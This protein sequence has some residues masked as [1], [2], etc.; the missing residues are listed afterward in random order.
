MARTGDWFQNVKTKE[1]VQLLVSPE[2]TDGTRIEAEM[3]LQPGGAVAAPHVH[4]ALHERFTVLEGELSVVLDGA[5]SVAGPGAVVDV[6]PGRAHDWSNAG[7]TVARVR[8]EVEGPAPM[9]T[10]FAEM[11]EVV[12]GLANTGHTDEHGKPTPLWLAALA[13]EYRDVIRLTSPPA[14]VQR[15]VLTPLAAIARRTGR[16]VRADWLHGAGCPAHAPAPTT[17]PSTVGG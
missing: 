4:D 14:V 1:L 5:R 8:V 7:T 16:D 17:P 10:R 15:I 6:P 3:W 9:A 12:F 2:E 11:I 13:T